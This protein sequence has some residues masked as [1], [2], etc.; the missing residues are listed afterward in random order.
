MPELERATSRSSVVVW[1][2]GGGVLGVFLFVSA[3][4]LY[5]RQL[6][7]NQ[8]LALERQKRIG[9]ALHQDHDVNHQFPVS[10][11]SFDGLPLHSIQTAL[12]PHLNQ[13]PLYKTLDQS[14]P[15]NAP[16]NAAATSAAIAEFINPADGLPTTKNG[17]GTA[18]FV[19]NARLFVPFQRVWIG[20]IY[21]GTSS[22]MAFGEIGHGVEPWARPGTERHLTQG[23]KGGESQFGRSNG[24]GGNILM[25][26]GQVRWIAAE[27]SPL[28]LSALSTHNGGENIE[29]TI[30]ASSEPATPPPP[31][32]P[33]IRLGYIYRNPENRVDFIPLGFKQDRIS[34][35]K[36][37]EQPPAVRVLLQNIGVGEL[38]V[39]GVSA[40]EGVGVEWL[41]APKVDLLKPRELAILKVSP[42]DPKTFRRGHCV[43]KT[44]DP[45]NP[46]ISME[47]E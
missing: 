3:A 40:T 34:F 8:S 14:Q 45:K 19:G 22:T 1:V 2:L 42:L 27:T 6:A 37:K 38:R 4:G 43:I 33:N 25:V 26:D 9:S 24:K 36:T 10:S 30:K 31:P 17:A 28:V 21:D 29:E 5:A 7:H 46:E 44:D 18:H 39:T 13:Q 20:H 23:M 35:W 47:I 16:A 15:W 32:L 41:S 11:Y 12:L